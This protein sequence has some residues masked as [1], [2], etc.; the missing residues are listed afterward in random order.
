MSELY[1]KTQIVLLVLYIIKRIKSFYL[2]FQNSS[3]CNYFSSQEIHLWISFCPYTCVK[4]GRR[5]VL[6]LFLTRLFAMSFTINCIYFT[7]LEGLS[8]QL[9]SSHW[10]ILHTMQACQ[11]IDTG[12]HW[13]GSRGRHVYMSLTCLFPLPIK[14]W[15]GMSTL[16]TTDMADGTRLILRKDIYH[17]TMSLYLLFS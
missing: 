4:G 2:E 10:L 11:L 15:A 16:N 12:C 13:H 5:E 9:F 14:L 3:S 6:K 17:R 7:F 8:K 1:P